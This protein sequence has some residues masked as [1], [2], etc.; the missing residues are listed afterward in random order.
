MNQ[1]IASDDSA[2]IMTPTGAAWFYRARNDRRFIH[3]WHRNVHLIWFGVMD[4]FGNLVHQPHRYV[5]PY[6]RW[7]MEFVGDQ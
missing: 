5:Q 1:P 2:W 4:D 7:Y 6:S 3:Y